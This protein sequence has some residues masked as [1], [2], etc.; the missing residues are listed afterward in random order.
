MTT[1]RLP[2]FTFGPM[3]GPWAKD[4]Q[5]ADEIANALRRIGG[6]SKLGDVIEGAIAEAAEHLSGT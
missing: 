2:P 5:R 3:S 6:R 4:V 1:S